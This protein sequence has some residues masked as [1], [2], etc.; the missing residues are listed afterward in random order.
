[1]N[2]KYDEDPPFYDEKGYMWSKWLLERYLLLNAS[3][4]RT[5][6]QNKEIDMIY[7]SAIQGRKAL[8]EI[9]KKLK[10]NNN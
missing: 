2:F 1:M 3:E 5:E 9:E 8:E 7:N 10:M 6:S 4:N